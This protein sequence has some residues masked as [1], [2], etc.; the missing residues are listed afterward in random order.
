MFVCSYH[1]F[2]SSQILEIPPLIRAI[3]FR[4]YY[5]P[6]GRSYS[7]STTYHTTVTQNDFKFNYTL[8]SLLKNT[9]YEIYVRAEGEYQWCSYNELIGENSEPVNMT[10]DEVGKFRIVSY[11]MFN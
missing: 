5:R 10:T 4:I 1:Y 7:S 3:D 8:S 2:C 11:L 9:T 6:R